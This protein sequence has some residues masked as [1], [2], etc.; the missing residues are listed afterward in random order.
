[1]G[2]PAPVTISGTSPFNRSHP[3]KPTPPT[4]TIMC[5]IAGQYCFDGRAPDRTL[6]E[7]MS[8][9]LVHRG[10][11]GAG[12]EIRGSTGLVHRRLAIIDLSEDGLQ[13]MTSEDGTL[14][15]VYNGEIYNYVELREEL[16]KKGHRFH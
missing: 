16:I 1:M 3:Y 8:D 13:P 4:F 9:Q 5:G 7:R 14:W 15:L 6:L 11:D 12:S 10:P 2:R